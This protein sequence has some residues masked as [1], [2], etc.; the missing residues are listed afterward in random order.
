[1][2]IS[3]RYLE[4]IISQEIRRHVLNER[5]KPETLDIDPEE[6]TFS[7]EAE[8]TR[9]EEGT[10]DETITGTIQQYKGR[11]LPK[12]DPENLPFGYESTRS[13]SGQLSGQLRDPI[14][15]MLGSVPNLPP[16][17]RQSKGK[18][19]AAALEAIASK[20]PDDPDVE[21]AI[22]EILNINMGFDVP[23]VG[24]PDH[25]RPGG[26]YAGPEYRPSGQS[27]AIDPVEEEEAEEVEEVNEI[28]RRMLK[29][30]IQKELRGLYRS[31]NRG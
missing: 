5:V 6:M 15:A 17:Q 7:V 13:V 25:L 23:S 11:H 29:R 19:L 28:S 1:M 18:I 16:A 30:A 22:W 24:I 3:K 26:K 21:A 27:Q 31:R 8:P 12:A 14:N 10:E 4:K 9:P 20:Y 2:K